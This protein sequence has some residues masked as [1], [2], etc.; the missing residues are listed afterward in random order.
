MK[1]RKGDTPRSTQVLVQR[2]VVRRPAIFGLGRPAAVHC[3]LVRVTR[4]PVLIVKPKPWRP[5]NLRG[6]NPSKD[7]FLFLVGRLIK[8]MLE[9]PQAVINRTLGCKWN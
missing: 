1:F 3:F 2:K 6:H 5:A 4:A 9:Q 8:D 7:S